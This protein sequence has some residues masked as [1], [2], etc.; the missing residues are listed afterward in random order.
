MAQNLTYYFMP[1]GGV[2]ATPDGTLPDGAVPCTQAQYENSTQYEINYGTT[3]PTIQAVAEATALQIAQSNQIMVLQNACENAIYSGY[4]SSALGSPYLYPA[5][6]T[7]QMNM[8]SSL[9]SAL[10]SVVFNAEDWEANTEVV[11][12]QMVWYKK[13][14]YVVT[15]NGETG[16][17]MPNWPLSAGATTIDGT[18]QWQLW[19]TPFWCADLSQNPVNWAFRLHTLRQIWQVG[20]DAKSS[21]LNDMGT[22]TLLADEVEAAQTVA[23]VEAIQWP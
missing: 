1:T 23:Q 22:N 19:T 17:T 2:G 12:G 8:L 13:Q 5:K 3:P 16:A 20:Q 6:A 9:V 7:D 18:A 14:L 10:G 11:A 15:A 4:Q 21:V